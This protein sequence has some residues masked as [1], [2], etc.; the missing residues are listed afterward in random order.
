MTGDRVTL[1]NLELRA[2]TGQLDG[3]VVAVDRVD[4]L[5]IEGVTIEGARTGVVAGGTRRL[6]LSDSVVEGCGL[7]VLIGAG[8]AL[9]S[10]D[11]WHAVLTGNRISQNTWG[12]LYLGADQPLN[13]DQE[14]PAL[15]LGEQSGLLTQTPY[16][17]DMVASLRV[18][19][20]SNDLSNNTG[21]FAHGFGIRVA[22]VFP[23][24]H[25]PLALSLTATNNRITGNNF[26]FSIDAGFPYR[27]PYYDWG[28]MYGCTTELKLKDNKVDSNTNGPALVTFNRSTVEVI[29]TELATFEFLRGSTIR[30]TTDGEL[31][32]FAWDNPDADPFDGAELDNHLYVNLVEVLPHGRNVPYASRGWMP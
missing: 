23:P 9:E 20:D 17:A 31:D 14:P 30:I 2:P 29:K 11:D 26:G 27:F 8:R 12:S 16:G 24:F 13:P 10:L 15:D 18:R 3:A 32:G 22:P 7:G 25:C 1:R 5:T 28:P 19:A 6:R 4:D 21:S